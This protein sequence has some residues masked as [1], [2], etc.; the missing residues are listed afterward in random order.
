MTSW[1]DQ[2][3][4]CLLL[5]SMDYF[6][7]RGLTL[8]MQDYFGVGGAYSDTSQT[9]VTGAG[10]VFAG[11]G[12]YSLNYPGSNYSDTLT[13]GAS[14]AETFSGNQG[15]AAVEHQTEDYLTV[16]MAFAFEA[17]PT[18]A[19]RQTVLQ[20]FIGHCPVD[21]QSVFSDGFESGDTSNWDWG[22]H[23]VPRSRTSRATIWKW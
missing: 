6:W 18:P 8:F 10:T 16:F 14:A 13:S 9:M 11:L 17:L 7:D 3:N 20:T 23:S 22:S 1:S 2:G 5:S 4:A 19:D 15:T 12:P 21:Q